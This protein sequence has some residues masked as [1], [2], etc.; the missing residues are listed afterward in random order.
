MRIPMFKAVAGALAAVTLVAA[1]PA[2]AG[3][4]YGHGGY[5]GGGGYYH[6]GGGWWGPAAAFG[7]LGL[8]TGAI[9][10]SQP[11]V[12][13]AYPVYD[14]PPPQVDGCWQ[15]RAVYDRYGRYLGRQSVNVCN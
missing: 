10:A 12:Y 5:Y 15:V 9:L 7:V 11:P 8:A 4:Y 6:G 3:G 14:V 13:P 1:S 2:L